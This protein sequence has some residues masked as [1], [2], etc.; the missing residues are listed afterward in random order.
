MTDNAVLLGNCWNGWIPCMQ[1]SW[2]KTFLTKIKEAERNAFN[3]CFSKIDYFYIGFLI[4]INISC[5]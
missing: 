1:V 3:V 4:I 2:C 5:A